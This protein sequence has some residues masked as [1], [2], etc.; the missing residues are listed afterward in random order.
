MRHQQKLHL[1]A[2]PTARQR[3]TRRESASSTAASGSSVRVR[4]SSVVNNT[5]GGS[6]AGIG[7]MRPR[8]NTIS[9]VDDATIGMLAAAGSSAIRHEGVD[10]GLNHHPVMNGLPGVGGFNFRGMSTAAGHHGNPHVLPKLETNGLNVTASLRTAPPY[11]GLGGE[12]D[13]E[14][15]WYG[16]GST[17]NPA[18]LHFSHSP[19]SLA[20][21]TPASPY[22]QSF[23]SIPTAH[24]ALDDD[25]NFKWL[26]GFE[27]QMSY[28]SIN[29]QAI[30]GS[31]P[32]V[33]S[34]GS[35]S[36]LSEVM[37]DG[38]PNPVASSAMWQNPMI[39]HAP[40]TSYSMDWSLPVYQDVFPSGQPSPKSLQ[41]HI[42]NNDQYFSNPPNM[43]I[44]T[45]A[46]M[47]YEM[48]DQCFHPPMITKPETPSNSA[49]STSSSNRHSS[50][51]SISTDS[52]TDAT[53]QALLASL[54]HSS[55]YNQNHLQISKP[56]PIIPS[57]A[58][59]GAMGTSLP[60]TYDLQR[61]VAAY[62]E[63]FHPHLPFLHVPSFLMS[64]SSSAHFDF[65]QSGPANS[66]SP[67]ILAMAAIGALYDYD[68]ATSKELSE[69]ANMMTQDYLEEIRI[70]NISTETNESNTP[71]WLVQAMAL[72]VI[73]SHQCGD[74]VAPTNAGAHCVT[75]VNL[76]RGVELTVPLSENLIKSESVQAGVEDVQYG[77]DGARA[78][79]WNS[80]RLSNQNEWFNWKTMEERKRT[81]YAVF[82]MSSILVSSH[83]HAQALTN[84]EIRLDL[85]CDEELWAA[86]SAETWAALGGAAAAE[87]RAVSF[88]SALSYLLTASQRQQQQPQLSAPASFDHQIIL[89]LNAINLPESDLKPSTFGCLILINA[90]HNYI[91]ETKQRHM[92]RQWTNHEMEAIHAHVEPALNA[93]QAAWVTNPHHSVQRPNSFGCGPLSADCIPLLDLAYIKL[94]TN[95]GREKET[96]WRRDYNARADDLAPSTEVIQNMDLIP[97]PNP[98]QHHSD[99]GSGTTDARSSAS[100]NIFI[101][102]EHLEPDFE[103]KLERRISFSQ[104]ERHLRNAA[105]YAANSLI[106][107]D[108]F[109]IAF[110]DLN[111]RD[112]PVQSAICAFDAA[113]V[114][115]EWVAVVQDRVGRFL[116][117]LGKDDIDFRQVPGIMLVEDEDC[118]LLDKLKEFIESVYAISTDTGPNEA[119]A[120]ALRIEDCG[121]GSKILLITALMLKKAP[122]WPG[123]S[124]VSSALFIF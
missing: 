17:V 53:R 31:S 60:S 105:Y 14:S 109:G 113:Q 58:S 8:A 22:H 19:Q 2:M 7:A 48:N 40:P 92:G 39:S 108:R 90:L 76:A 74:M 28:N 88:A 37:L 32:S 42:I 97:N 86:D 93:W 110:A 80:S 45:S 68:I 117:I 1:T 24:A 55:V 79:S 34:T 89:N 112:L 36:G 70:A 103:H 61:Y 20:F 119:C 94:S 51:T 57:Q 65:T 9:H 69:M 43:N 73:Y 5:I 114:L 120:A 82:T 71:L 77:G 27:T 63:Y 111:S 54:S 30:D 59:F 44:Q 33:I 13:M 62:I 96:F 25:G 102:A 4:K 10:F 11:G 49:A 3:G 83:N 106:M 64:Q 122:I 95:L 75:L 66:K 124:V 101:E 123:K 121:Y 115:A 118:Q 91:W 98:G 29:E 38:C 56:Q 50:V 100:A 78:R 104:H 67:L 72:N 46:P 87:Q 84:S 41:T 47:M 116:G 23:P 26:N 35:R 18:Q 52:I 16:P 15:M 107:S 99:V 81:L 12:I 21:E 85:P 6:S